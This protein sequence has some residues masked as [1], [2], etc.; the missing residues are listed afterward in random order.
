MR[1]LLLII[2]SLLFI[3]CAYKY[4]GKQYTESDFVHLHYVTGG[5]NVD[6]NTDVLYLYRGGSSACPIFKADGTCLTL[7]EWQNQKSK[8]K[9][10]LK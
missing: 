3:S 2:C 7:T 1:N 6:V 9:E 10:N 8:A 5:I 4:E